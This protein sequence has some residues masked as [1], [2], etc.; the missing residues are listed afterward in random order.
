M[1]I[2]QSVILYTSRIALQNL[3]R[4]N[5]DELHSSNILHRIHSSE[6]KF[7]YFKYYKTTAVSSIFAE[8]SDLIICAL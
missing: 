2:S 3:K 6:V 7:M 4:I 8:G 1:F 5:F